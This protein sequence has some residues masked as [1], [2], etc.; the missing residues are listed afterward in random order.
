MEWEDK[1]WLIGGICSFTLLSGGIVGAVLS[2]S[3]P[4]NNARKDIN[5][6]IRAVM[7]D[8]NLNI[9]S[10]EG[11]VFDR[12]NNVFEVITKANYN[13]VIENE[14]FFYSFGYATP[15]ELQKYV[16][17]L[18]SKNNQVAIVKI[19]S[20]EGVEFFKGVASATEG[21]VI[22]YGPL[23]EEKTEMWNELNNN[24]SKNQTQE[25]VKT[26]SR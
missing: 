20:N 24:L 18:Y 12:E 16:N 26:K 2:T 25:T 9:E 10:V 19:N 3:I 14:S 6:N 22:S 4:T 11:F 13:K 8:E 5:H 15:E 23:S 1:V 17:M 7:I 21:E